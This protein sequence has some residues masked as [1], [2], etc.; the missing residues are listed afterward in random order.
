MVGLYQSLVRNYMTLPFEVASIDGAQELYDWFGYWPSFH[1]AEVVRLELNRSGPSSLSVLTRE[2]TGEVDQKGYHVPAKNAT[3]DFMIEGI[4]DLDLNGFSHQN[5]VN[6][7]KIEKTPNGFL[8]TLWPCYGLA[9]T[10]DSSKISI[11]VSPEKP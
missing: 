3:V 1:D 8:V 4:S 6:N 10:I 9:G 11:Q 5:V 2:T 7:I